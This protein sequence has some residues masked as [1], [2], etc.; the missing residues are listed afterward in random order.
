MLRIL[1]LPGA[2]LAHKTEPLLRAVPTS[3][4]LQQRT[5]VLNRAG[6]VQAGQQPGLPGLLG[7]QITEERPG[8][9]LVR[10][11]ASRLFIV[12]VGFE[13]LPLGRGWGREAGRGPGWGAAA[14][15]QARG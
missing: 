14:H 11:R 1:V 7:G 8:P 15:L 4:L 9:G 5:S 2:S 13:P 12:L 3:R 6:A 10:I